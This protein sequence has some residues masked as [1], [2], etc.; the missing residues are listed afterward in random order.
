[1]KRIDVVLNHLPHH[2]ESF[3]GNGRR[4]GCSIVTHLARRVDRPYRSLAILPRMAGHDELW[5]LGHA[6]RLPLV[7][8]FAE[9]DLATQGPVLFRVASADGITSEWTGWALLRPRDLQGLSPALTEPELER[10]LSGLEGARS[11]LLP[12][13]AFLD[14]RTNEAYLECQRRLFDGGLTRLL[15]YARE[16]RPGVWLSRNVNVDPSAE[17]VP[18]VLIGHDSVV[19][20]GARIGPYVTVGGDSLLDAGSQLS[21]TVIFPGT[22]VG[23]AVAVDHAIVDRSLLIDAR[24]GASVT[25]HDDCVLGDTSSVGFGECLR[26]AAERCLALVLLLL[27]CPALLAVLVYRVIA[28]G[29]PNHPRPCC[30]R[31]SGGRRS[32]QENVFRLFGWEKENDPP[33]HGHGCAPTLSGLLFQLLP[34]LV[35]VVKGDLRLVGLPPRTAAEVERL[36]RD[37]R[38]LYLTERTGLVTESATRLGPTPSASEVGIAETYYA[39]VADWK[40]DLKLLALFLGRI[41]RVWSPEEVVHTYVPTPAEAPSHGRRRE[42]PARDIVV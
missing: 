14:V 34:G 36:P 38:H 35:N 33:V 39:V 31:V 22:Y 26:N 6:D 37:W 21:N 18:P 12:P 40:Y 7:T 28:S 5:L 23:E 30:L 19:G 1:V 10:Y 3:L 42:T 24:I 25:L 32:S 8:S 29:G 15:N 41:F 20:K 11:H 4:W 27:T 13:E 2:V 9:A 17:I 16:V